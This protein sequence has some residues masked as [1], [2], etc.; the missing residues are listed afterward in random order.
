MQ[1]DYPEK[2]VGAAAQEYLARLYIKYD[3]WDDAVRALKKLPEEYEE[4]RFAADAYFRIGAIFQNKLEQPDS[5][6]VYYEK[7]IDSYPGIRP[8][9]LAKRSIE[10]L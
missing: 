6:R 7:Q 5:A 8:S 9:D 4:Y 2:P 10:T 1:H 3:Q